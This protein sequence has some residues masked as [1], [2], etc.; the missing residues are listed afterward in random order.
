VVATIENAILCNAQDY[1]S[2][3]L[4]AKQLKEAFDELNQ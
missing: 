2:V 4:F 3:Y 1:V